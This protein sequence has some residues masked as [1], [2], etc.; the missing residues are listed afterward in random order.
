MEMMSAVSKSLLLMGLCFA[1]L[2]PGPTNALECY[3]CTYLDGYSDDSC[4]TNASAVKVLNCH[5]KYC[6]TMRQESIRNASKVISFLRD[7]QDKPMM[8]NGNTPDGSFRTYY[9]S[10]QQNLCNGHNGRINNSTGGSASSSGIHNAIVPGKN[11]AHST[12]HGNRYSF[13]FG[14][15]LFILL[16]NRLCFCK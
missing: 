7:C 9:N 12:G 2:S 5:K 1:L 13:A 4:V 15:G 8:P 14:F 3:V 11:T 10:C 16:S 6:L